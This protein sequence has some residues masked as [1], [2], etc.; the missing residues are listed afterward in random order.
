MSF[1][2]GLT[3][4][5]GTGKSTVS[6][7]FKELGFPVIDADAGARAVVEPGQP[8]LA[9]VIEHFGEEYVFPNQTLNR[10]KLAGLI[11][12]NKPA[13]E[14]LNQI[15]DAHIRQWIMAQI[16]KYEA[17]GHQL[18]VL[19][20]PLLYEN[21]YEAVCDEIMVIYVSETTQLK[22]L[23]QR[24]NLTESEATD[25]VLSQM[26]ITRKAAKADVVI[27]NSGTIFETCQQIDAWLAVH[28][29]H[30]L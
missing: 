26:N 23:M 5:I 20:I 13:R 6:K 25:R 27:D 7:Y 12:S 10:K 17:A 1:R 16:E 2:L 9:A 24:D 15:L 30:P 3:G 4:S 22:R 14:V 28:D 21:S 29:F 18:I 19:D 8:G 11:F